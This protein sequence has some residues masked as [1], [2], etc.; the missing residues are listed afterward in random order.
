ML[1]KSSFI[2][3]VLACLAFFG[4]PL[5]AQTEVTLPVSSD[6]TSVIGVTD[7]LAAALQGAF[8][9]TNAVVKVRDR[10]Y[11]ASNYMMMKRYTPKDHHKFETKDFFDKTFYSLR[12]ASLKLGTEDYPYGIVGGFSF[13][14]WFHEDHALRL[15]VSAGH[16]YDNFNGSDIHAAELSLTYAFNVTSYLGGYKPERFCNLSVLM[17]AGYANSGYEGNTGQGVAAHAGLN[18]DMKL[19]PMVSFFVEPLAKVYSNGM[20]ISRAGNWRSWLSAFEGSIGLSFT[21]GAPEVDIAGG[22]WFMSLVGGTQLQNSSNVYDEI[23]IANALGVHASI[24]VGHYVTDYMAF[25]GTLA[26]SRDKWVQYDE[27]LLFS[28]YFALRVEGMFDIVSALSRSKERQV[29]GLCIL[30]GPELGYMYKDDYGEEYLAT[31]YIGLAG[32]VQLKFALSRKVRM[33]FE[34]RCSMVP[35]TGV[36]YDRTTLNDYVNYYDGLINMNIGLEFDL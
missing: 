3:V 23:G 33:F 16:W 27:L 18:I 35:Y 19:S 36:S 9:D 31:P 17:G 34:P 26:Y 25:R 29:V 12:A 1:R 8:V 30:L 21:A 14:K 6:T 7:S 4:R 11:D 20:A 13:G 2:L 5:S 28:N 10:G 22:S 32:G 24:G 15:N